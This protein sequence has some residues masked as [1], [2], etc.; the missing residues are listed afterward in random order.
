METTRMDRRKKYSLKMIRQA[1]LELLREKNLSSITVT[2][3][4]R[5]ADVNRG[6]F[7]KYYRDIDDLFQQI[8]DAFSNEIYNL[9]VCSHDTK[10]NSEKNCYELLKSALDIMSQNTDLLMVLKKTNNFRAI[11]SKL[12]SSIYPAASVQLRKML[13]KLPERDVEYLIEFIIGG[14]GTIG[15]KWLDDDMRMSKDQVADMM[16]KAINGILNE[17][18]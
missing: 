9:T 12:I 4:C 2:E 18:R 17:Y 11:V 15:H 8:C 16:Y 7:Y 3:V 1:F 6:T 13:P 14:C 10:D 5:L